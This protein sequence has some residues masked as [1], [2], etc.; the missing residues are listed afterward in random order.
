MAAGEQQTKTVTAASNL[1]GKRTD[2]G[3]S[4]VAELKTYIADLE[5]EVAARERERDEARARQQ[6]TLH[7]ARELLDELCSLQ[8]DHEFEPR[9]GKRQGYPGFKAR[10]EETFP[11]LKEVPS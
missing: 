10:W 6:E 4:Y 1:P 9:E 3:S 8:A 5:I 2:S 11:W 7:G